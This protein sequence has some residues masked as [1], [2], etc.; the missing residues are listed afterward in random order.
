MSGEYGISGDPAKLECGGLTPRNGAAQTGTKT[1][2]G[3]RGG[4]PVSVRLVD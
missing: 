4:G 2:K 1:E 3:P